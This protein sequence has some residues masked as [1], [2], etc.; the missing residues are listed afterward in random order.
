MKFMVQA[1]ISIKSYEYK[2]ARVKVKIQNANELG[3]FAG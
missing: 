2:D 3:S 1:N